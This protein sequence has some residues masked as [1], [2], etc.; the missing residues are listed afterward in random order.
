LCHATTPSPKVKGKPLCCEECHLARD[1]PPLMPPKR[2]RK[3]YSNAESHELQL[4]GPDTGGLDA[5]LHTVYND[6]RAANAQLL[7][8]QARNRA[9]EIEVSQLKERTRVFQAV[10]D[11]IEAEN[12]RLQ[13]E[14]SRLQSQPVMPM[15]LSGRTF[16]PID[17]NA[18]VFK[19]EK[20]AKSSGGDKFVCL[21][22]PDFNI[23]FPQCISRHDSARP[24]QLLHLRVEQFA[25]SSS[26]PPSSRR[27]ED[28]SN[29]LNMKN[30]SVKQER[31]SDDDDDEPIVL[32]YKA[33]RTSSK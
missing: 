16:Q 12:A 9:L 18:Y 27:P 11:S 26:N 31:V 15:P 2:T 10:R 5:L 23:Y 22:Q 32:S 17:S 30:E 1:A 21:A 19:L 29:G 8:E 20:A 28:G 7:V 24:C 25:D 6:L 14:V 33:G 3:L 4:D 13:I